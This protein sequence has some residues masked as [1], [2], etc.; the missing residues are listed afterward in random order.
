M[1]EDRTR[2]PGTIEKVQVGEE[3]RGILTWIFIDFVGTGQGFGGL[4]LD[5]GSVK[6]W[7]QSLCRT[8]DVERYEDLVGKKCFALR[9]W[10]TW[11]ADIEGL[12]SESGKR[13]TLH[14]FRRFLWPEKDWD[15]LKLKKDACE[16]EVALL[17]RRLN[18]A[19]VALRNVAIGY[20]EW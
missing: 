10:P 20:K 6:V 4:I 13:F 3:D 12:E 7:K 14:A 9:N 2:E 19:R 18:E 16:R 8:F 15:P 5:P 1:T 11:G 17:E